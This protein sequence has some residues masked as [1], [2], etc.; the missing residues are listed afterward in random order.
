MVGDAAGGVGGAQPGEDSVTR[1]RPV[2]HR[3]VREGLT[4]IQYLRRTSIAFMFGWPVVGFAAF[5]VGLP[6][7]GMM[8]VWALGGTVLWI[9]LTWSRCP[10]CGR[11]F[12]SR[13]MF[14]LPAI[15]VFRRRYSECGLDIRQLN[16]SVTDDEPGTRPR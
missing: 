8:A 15:A 13:M 10:R 12:Y 3:G 7:P 9:I 5:E 6:A 4:R 16:V 1:L 14:F 11:F 2:L